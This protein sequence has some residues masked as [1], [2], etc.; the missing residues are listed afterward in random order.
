MELVVGAHDIRRENQR[1]VAPKATGEEGRIAGTNG[2][3]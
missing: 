3:K 2:E 1:D